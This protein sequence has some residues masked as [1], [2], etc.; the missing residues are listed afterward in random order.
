MRRFRG[1]PPL[2]FGFLAVFAAVP[3]FFLGL[4]QQAAF[5]YIVAIVLVI[6]GGF[7]MGSGLHDRAALLI[8]DKDDR[9]RALAE[10]SKLSRTA[11][12]VFMVGG[13]VAVLMGF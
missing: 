5:F 1:V 9:E 4:A 12:I 6:S 13:L 2:V 3:I 10:G 11:L 8:K 7:L